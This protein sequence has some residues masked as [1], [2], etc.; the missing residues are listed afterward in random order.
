MIVTATGGVPTRPQFKS[1]LSL[2]SALLL[3]SDILDLEAARNQYLCRR[4]LTIIA[5]A[6]IFVISGAVLIFSVV[7]DLQN[8]SEVGF[9]DEICSTNDLECIENKCPNGYKWKSDLNSCEYIEG[10]F[11]FS[12]HV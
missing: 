12:F 4:R 10:M 1:T 7:H 3:D 5:I 8:R 9:I 6:A 2:E 11:I